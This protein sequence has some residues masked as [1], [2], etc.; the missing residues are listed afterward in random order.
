MYKDWCLYSDIQEQIRQ[1]LN[2]PNTDKLKDIPKKGNL[3]LEDIRN[4]AYCFS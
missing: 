2:N 1:Q 4:S 3:N